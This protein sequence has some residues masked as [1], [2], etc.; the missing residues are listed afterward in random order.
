MVREGT[1]GEATGG[2]AAI[3]L[4]LDTSGSMLQP[5]EGQ[6]RIDIARD[7]LGQLVSE[8]IP[9]GTP[10]AL[11]VFGDTPESCETNLIA[12]LQPLDPG[13]MSGLI[14]GLQAIDGVNTPIAA[15][16][17]QV[18]N[19]LHGAEGTRIVV[20]VTDGEETCGGDPVAA[21]RDIAAQGIDAR[22]NIVGFAVENE[23]L[24]AQFR[25]WAH[26]GNGQYFDAAGAAD[27]GQAIAAAVQP[28]YRVHD[29]AGNEIARGLVDGA[30][31]E[32]PSGTYRVE[33]QAAQTVIIDNV[34]VGSGVRAVVPWGCQ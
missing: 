1:E 19:D 2:S 12:P 8:T 34:E 5:L 6:R 7:V 13:S 28:P 31:V 27:L 16:L 24:K 21:L 30:P 15:S 10:L 23:A 29:A 18:A 33:V 20:L 3:D 9:P 17:A 25:E 11:R 32:V 26:L 22:V 14:S 4:I